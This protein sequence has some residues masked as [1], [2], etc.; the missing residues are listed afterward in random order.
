MEIKKRGQISI[1]ICISLI[2]VPLIISYATTSY[3]MYYTPEIYYSG[4]G[5]SSNTQNIIVRFS[6]LLSYGACAFMFLKT[7]LNKRIV[8]HKRFIPYFF[9]LM[10]MVFVITFI[11]KDPITFLST[12]G[13][14][15][16]RLSIITLFSCSIYFWVYQPIYWQYTIKL[17][18]YITIIMT[19]IIIAFL[20]TKPE[21]YTNRLYSLKWLH[22]YGVIL[23]LMPFLFLTTGKGIKE[24][25]FAITVLVVDLIMII[26]LQTRLYVVDILLYTV[27]FWLL[28]LKN[29]KTN[30]NKKQFKFIFKIGIVVFIAIVV[31]SILLF[32]V[33]SNDII[34]S[35]SNISMSLK[36]FAN[37]LF[38]DTRTNQINNFMT[39]FWDSFPFGVGY[40][41]RGIMSGSGA[42]GIDNG[43]L[44]TIYMVGLPMVFF[45]V[46]FT[47][48]P[49]LA[50]W[51]TNLSL[52]DIAIVARGT[53][54]IVILSSST[55]TAY[56][57]EFLI[58]IICAGRC[59][60]LV[61][62]KRNTKEENNCE[63]V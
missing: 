34:L 25:Y 49:I 46:L 36:M 29:L 11:T 1:Y 33:N 18:K 17:L 4:S 30:K 28:F 19:V 47:I 13:M 45:L 8:K 31:L 38:E 3:S 27:L 51:H 16:D 63:V 2:L 58:F 12:P 21:I 40:N 50:A 62:S 24:R 54:W 44:N 56:T 42:Y 6:M 57:I 22:G 37:R 7:L 23:R 9:M 15:T 55:T 35:D 52:T 39:Y 5:Y 43:Y 41:T 48:Q 20:L 59:A 53:V 61:D 32:K 10:S 26:V 14:W 60:W